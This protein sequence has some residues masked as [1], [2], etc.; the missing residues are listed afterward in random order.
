MFVCQRITCNLIDLPTGN[1]VLFGEMK[2][3]M[4]QSFTVIHSDIY[5]VKIDRKIND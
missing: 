2:Q 3:K 5:V 4:T 1:T